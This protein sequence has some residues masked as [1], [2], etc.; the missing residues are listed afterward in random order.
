MFR[1]ETETFLSRDYG[2]EPFC[3]A[4]QRFLVLGTLPKH[5]TPQFAQPALARIPLSLGKSLQRK[6]KTKIENRL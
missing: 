2:I 5:L 4:E 6:L 3:K 1:F